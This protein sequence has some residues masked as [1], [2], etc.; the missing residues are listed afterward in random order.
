MDN[1]R[2]NLTIAIVIDFRIH[3]ITTQSLECMCYSCSDYDFAMNLDIDCIDYFR[4]LEVADSFG[5][6]FG[7]D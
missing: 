6:G 2:V 7:F 3:S 1:L 5:F 4:P